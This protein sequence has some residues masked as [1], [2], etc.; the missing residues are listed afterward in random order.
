M[1]TL[2][3][4]LAIW[5]ANLQ[6]VMEY[7]ASFLT[8]MLGMML[9]NALYFVVWVIFFDRF[10]QVRG[11]GLGNMYVTFGISASAFGLVS[12]FLGNAFS[13]GD[14]ITRGRLD[15]YLSL[16]RPVLL[17]TLVSRSTPH[18]AGDVLYGLLSFAVSGYISFDGL[19]RFL[20]AMLLG[21]VVFC[22]F[23]I[24][25]QSLAFWMG[26]ASNLVALA[27]NA[28]ITFAIYPIDIFDSGA[29]LLL[30]T[31]IPA[32]LMGAVPASFAIAFTWQALAQLLAGALGLLGAA[33]ALFHLGLK[34]YESGSAIQMEI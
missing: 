18:G 31:L 28:M 13:L 24:I 26:S 2:R 25:L 11:W 9:N 7:R 15:Y 30:F 23:L 8:Q 20:L 21:A 4:L 34:R 14:I 22:S 29:K 17:H 1:S 12:L 27:N 6:S 5:K 19:L 32:A 33:L 10:Q 3:F 16:P